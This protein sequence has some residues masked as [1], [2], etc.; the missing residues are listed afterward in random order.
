M[1]WGRIAAIAAAIA[2]VLWLCLDSGLGGAPETPAVAS[3]A[4]LMLAA[5]FG[6]GAWVMRVG[7]RPERVP[8]LAGAA[9]GVAAYALVRLTLPG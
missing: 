2:A 9:I 5:V 7:G 1:P 3:V 4:L 6:T 8:L